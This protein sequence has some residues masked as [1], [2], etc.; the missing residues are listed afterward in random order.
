[1]PGFEKSRRRD[2]GRFIRVRPLF[3]DRMILA[4][5]WRV[6]RDEDADHAP[7]IRNG[8]WVGRLCLVAVLFFG[9]P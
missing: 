4:E 3:T 7:E 5:D 6:I 9:V 8:Y 2:Y 1:M